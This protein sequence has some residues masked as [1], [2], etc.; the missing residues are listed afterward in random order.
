MTVTC[1]TCV[2]KRNVQLGRNALAT[3][4]KFPSHI[5]SC[6]ASRLSSHRSVCTDPTLDLCP[7]LA[8]DNN[9]TM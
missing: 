9:L 1:V 8:Q 3:N 6:R 4:S 5:S 7:S 2:C